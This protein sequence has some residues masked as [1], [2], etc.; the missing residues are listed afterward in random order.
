MEII[1]YLNSLFDEKYPAKPPRV[2][3][4]TA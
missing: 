3:K 2:A 1:R 4:L